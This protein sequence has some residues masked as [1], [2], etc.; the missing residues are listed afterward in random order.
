[1]LISVIALSGCSG[2]DE[3]GSILDAG[4]PDEFLVISKAPLVMPPDMNLRPPH[5]GAAQIGDLNPRL[6]ARAAITGLTDQRELSVRSAG[7]KV[8]LS[9]LNTGI[10]NSNVREQLLLDQGIAT[11]ERKFLDQ[12]LGIEGK[13]NKALEPYS[14]ADRLRQLQ[15][16]DQAGVP[17]VAPPGLPQPVISQAKRQPSSGLLDSILGEY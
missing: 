8:F 7:E 5:A 17:L 3:T 16:E 1:M 6:A 12:V 11:K 13:G 9:R 14:E 2:L 10:N 15:L 4:S